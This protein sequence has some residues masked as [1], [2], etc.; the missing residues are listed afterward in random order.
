MHATQKICCTV[1]RRNCETEVF[2]NIGKERVGAL[3]EKCIFYY[4][5]AIGLATMGLGVKPG[6][7]DKKW[8]WK[9]TS[10]K[11]GILSSLSFIITFV[12]LQYY[13][14]LFAYLDNYRA[15][16]RPEII[17]L[18]IIDTTIASGVTIILVT[19]CMRQKNMISWMNQ[20]LRVQ[21]LLESEREI[22]KTVYEF[23]H[24]VALAVGCVLI[25]MVISWLP[26]DHNTYMRTYNVA[27]DLCV[28]INCSL[29]L[30]YSFVVKKLRN[31]FV[32]LDDNFIKYSGY[33]VL[34]QVVQTNQSIKFLKILEL[35]DSL[36]QICRNVSNFYSLP[37]LF[38]VLNC[39]MSSIICSYSLTKHTI[40]ENNRMNKFDIINSCVVS[41]NLMSILTLVVNVTWTME[42]VINYLLLLLFK[43]FSKFFFLY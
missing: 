26:F 6:I 15:D 1:K 8:T 19:F 37:M 38:A 30:Q 14:I 5:K 11:I 39:F 4:F 2:K 28:L 32:T 24:V 7:S 9:F 13:G 31:L 18:V 23:D 35:H 43:K 17:L 41:M 12:T 33:F 22:E 10:S 27:S 21:K 25:F 42:E 3:L 29:I 40:I 36:L 20:I 16:Y 34:Y